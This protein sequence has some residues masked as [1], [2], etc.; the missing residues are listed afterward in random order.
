MGCVQLGFEHLQG[1]EGSTTFP[2]NLFKC[3]TALILKK[4]PFTCLEK[5]LCGN[6]HPLPL[7]LLLCILEKSLRK[8][9]CHLLHDP[10]QG[11][12]WTPP[13]T[14]LLPAEQTQLPQPLVLRHVLQPPE[15]LDN[16]FFIPHSG[17][18]VD[19]FFFSLTAFKYF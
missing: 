14:A 12:S 15:H 10:Q 13:Q 8:A 5:I 4:F 1:N 3:L 19:Y 17:C 7:V 6:L 2:C 9:C 11:S 16:P 18:L